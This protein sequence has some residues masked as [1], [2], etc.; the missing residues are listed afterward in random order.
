MDD[1]NRS[2]CEY[3][4]S[5]EY[6]KDA[7]SWYASK[8]IAIASIRTYIVFLSSFFMFCLLV[9]TFFYNITDPAP[10]EISYR[11]T[12]DDIAQNY[13]VIFPAGKDKDP[14]QIQI[15]KYLLSKYVRIREAYDINKVDS[16]LNFIMNTT[17]APN[18]IL[19][20]KQMSINNP[21]SPLMLYQD[22]YRKEIQIQD[23]KL[24]EASTTEKEAII[25]YKE[26]LRNIATNRV[27]SRNMAA[28]ITYKVDQIE[29][30]VGTSASKMN[31]LV[32]NYY[33]I[34]NK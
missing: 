9:L 29:N 16:Q 24:L 8:F 2:I 10:P 27:D 28:R 12:S 6:Y 5:G 23:V 25:F 19:F 34:E 30:L 21:S 31:F 13:S 1:L 11:I 3:I 14:P 18:Y 32:F 15:T 7:R 22:Q 4:K 20:E 26:S 33:V 17:V